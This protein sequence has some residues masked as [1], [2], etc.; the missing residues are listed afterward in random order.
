MTYYILTIIF[1]LFLGATA[2]ATFA[3]KSP[4]SDR[5]RIYWN[6]SFLKLIGLFLWPTLLLGIIILS[7]NWKLSLLIIILALF[8]QKMILVPISEKIIISP[9]HLL[10]NK[11]K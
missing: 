11:K 9:L 8:L 6:E 4:R 1:L 5:P 2:S 10:L 7:M 3:E